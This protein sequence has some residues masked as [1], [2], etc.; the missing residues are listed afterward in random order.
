MAQGLAELESLLPRMICPVCYHT[1][2]EAVLRCDLAWRSCLPAIHCLHCGETI[3]PSQ[4][5][6][7]LRAIEQRLHDGRVTAACPDCG[8]RHP[9]V[10]FRCELVDRQCSYLL[11]CRHCGTVRRVSL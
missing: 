2:L 1:E 3:D 4:Y 8:D 5:R 10:E 7:A 11:R 9:M 6:L